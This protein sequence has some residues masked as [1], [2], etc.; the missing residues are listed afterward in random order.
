MKRFAQT[1]GVILAALTVLAFIPIFMLLLAACLCVALVLF[2]ICFITG[3]PIQVKKNGEVI[4]EI[5]YFEFR[6]T[7]KPKDPI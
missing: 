3:V 5:V 4:G 2:L 7:K 6:P 1:V